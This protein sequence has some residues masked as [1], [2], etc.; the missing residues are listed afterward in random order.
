MA[1]EFGDLPPVKQCPVVGYFSLVAS[2][3]LTIHEC[4]DIKHARRHTLWVASG[5]H[6]LVD[7]KFKQLYEHSK[8]KKWS[9]ESHAWNLWRFNAGYDI[10]YHTEAGF[11]KTSSVISGA[12]L[13]IRVRLPTLVGRY[14]QTPVPIGIYDV[15]GD[16]T[17]NIVSYDSVRCRVWPKFY[18]SGRYWYELCT[19]SSSLWG[20]STTTNNFGA[21]L[22]SQVWLW[23]CIKIAVFLNFE[24][25]YI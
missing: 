9:P 21:V 7:K 23:N 15:I 19:L 2:R 3:L 17:V 12:A 25:K 13:G 20:E 24:I 8:R 4:T 18:A 14:L 6:Q 5:R 1:R 22:S 10:R 11:I 16:A